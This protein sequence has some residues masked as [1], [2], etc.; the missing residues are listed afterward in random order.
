M[1]VEN[2]NF[3]LHSLAQFN[4]SKLGF[5]FLIVIFF[6]FISFGQSRLLEDF[7]TPSWQSAFSKEIAPEGNLSVELDTVSPYHGE[8]ALSLIVDL[9]A[10]LQSDGFMGTVDNEFFLVPQ[11]LSWDINPNEIEYFVYYIKSDIPGFI[12]SV[13]VYTKKTLWTSGQSAGG[14]EWKQ[15]VI[16]LKSMQ[17]TNTW[18]DQGIVNDENIAAFT[19]PQWYRIENNIP[20]TQP[21]PEMDLDDIQKI[22]MGFNSENNL[23]GKVFVDNVCVVNDIELTIPLSHSY[24]SFYYNKDNKLLVFFGPKLRN[25]EAL[26]SNFVTVNNGALHNNIYSGLQSQWQ[27]DWTI[28]N[29][30]TSTITINSNVHFKDST[31]MLSKKYSFTTTTFDG[32]ALTIT[33]NGAAVTYGEDFAINFPQGFCDSSIT[34]RKDIKT[35]LPLLPK[36]F[37]SYD[38]RIVCLTPAISLNKP[39]SIYWKVNDLSDVLQQHPNIAIYTKDENDWQPLITKRVGN[40][41]YLKASTLHLGEYTLI[42]TSMNN[43]VELLSIDSS[44]TILTP[45]GDGRND[46][47]KFFLTLEKDSLVSL[48]I[49]DSHGRL[50]KRLAQEQ[51]MTSG[52]NS[53]LI[54]DGRDENGELVNSGIYV[55]HVKGTDSGNISKSSELNKIIG[56]VR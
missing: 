56:V 40:S 54:W 39:V 15:I 48:E 35:A 24:K 7:E 2:M 4:H 37:Q 11:S 12:F 45:N 28:A 55:Y 3:K 50:I 32:D 38:N 25:S 36:N 27:A 20:I 52:I 42:Y 53:T 30:Q 22:G 6:L 1:K 5:L 9:P 10:K 51:G 34:L 46:N 8:A 49:Y 13:N 21:N 31:L 23:N 44:T 18:D 26:D 41:D 43:D 17:G 47:V 33:T 16:P 29:N 19:I 14:T